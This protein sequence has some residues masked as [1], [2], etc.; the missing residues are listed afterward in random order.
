MALATE[1]KS[2]LCIIPVS[3]GM[4]FLWSVEVSTRRSFG[5]LK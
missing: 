4:K 5:L 1:K 3:N 2:Y